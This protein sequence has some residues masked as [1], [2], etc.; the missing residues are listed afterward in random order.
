MGSAGVAAWAAQV[1]FGALLLLGVLWGDLG[2]RR[3]LFFVVLWLA[4]YF[5]LPLFSFGGVSGL[6]AAF[7]GPYVAILDTSSLSLFSRVTSS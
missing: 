3:A 4:G 5:A 6:G 7:F 2:V 1:M